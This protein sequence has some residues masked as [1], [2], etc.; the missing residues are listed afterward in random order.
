MSGVQLMA[1]SFSNIMGA[2]SSGQ[3]PGIGNV[4]TVRS[5]S[6]KH[7]DSNANMPKTVL[8]NENLAFVLAQ[9]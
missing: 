1:T 7:H 9:N 8:G 5:L 6:Y 3:V 2:N 4:L